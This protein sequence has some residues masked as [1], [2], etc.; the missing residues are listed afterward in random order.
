MQNTLRIV[1]LVVRE[2]K[3]N[4]INSFIILVYIIYTPVIK[5]DKKLPSSNCQYTD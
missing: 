2:F 1:Q 3:H 5:T 4:E